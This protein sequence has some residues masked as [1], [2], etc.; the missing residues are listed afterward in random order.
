MR[1]DVETLVAPSGLEIGEVTPVAIAIN[2]RGLQVRALDSG[3]R[4]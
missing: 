4:E 3:T 1:P 2:Y